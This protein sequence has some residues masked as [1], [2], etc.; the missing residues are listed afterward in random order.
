MV[1][2]ANGLHVIVVDGDDVY[3]GMTKLHSEAA[4]GGGRSIKLDN[5]L[6]A[7]LVPS[8]DSL[9]LRFSTGESIRMHNR[10]GDK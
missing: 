1:A 7:Q 4:P 10:E 8:G 6:V 9:N 5:G 3:A 2:F